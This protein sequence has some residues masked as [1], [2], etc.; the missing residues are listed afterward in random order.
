LH[1]TS[2]RDAAFGVPH[3]VLPVRAHEVRSLYRRMKQTNGSRI[4]E[5]TTSS[6]TE[7]EAF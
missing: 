2:A 6:Y 4:S 5:E 1:G 7:Y 3:F